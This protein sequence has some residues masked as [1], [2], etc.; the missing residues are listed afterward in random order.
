MH[1]PLLPPGS[2]T[3]ATSDF[4]FPDLTW[5][6]LAG[7]REVITKL[8]SNLSC[9]Q[10]HICHYGEIPHCLPLKEKLP[11]LHFLHFK[12]VQRLQVVEGG[13]ARTAAGGA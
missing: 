9:S 3:S 7:V 10:L 5:I 4:L 11:L 8:S 2:S 12:E 13:R 6:G 1:I